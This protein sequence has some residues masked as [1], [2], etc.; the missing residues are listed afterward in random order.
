[1]DGNGLRR[2]SKLIYQKLKGNIDGEIWSLFEKI[3]LEATNSNP[4]GEDFLKSFANACS[5]HL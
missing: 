5:N 4:Q 3:H 2:A 1:M